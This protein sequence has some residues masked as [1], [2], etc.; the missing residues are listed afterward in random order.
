[1]EKDLLFASLIAGFSQKFKTNI[2]IK[3]LD[4]IVYLIQMAQL[5]YLFPNYFQ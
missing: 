4:S 5:I 1:M 2:C 3:E